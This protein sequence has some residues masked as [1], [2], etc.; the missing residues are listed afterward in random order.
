[1]CKQKIMAVGVVTVTIVC[2]ILDGCVS[3]EKISL[4]KIDT[5][6]VNTEKE[7]DALQ[8][9]QDM[10]E[11][12]PKTYEVCNKSFTSVCEETP[13]RKNVFAVGGKQIW[14][15]GSRSATGDVGNLK[16]KTYFVGTLEAPIMQKDSW[17]IKEAGID[18]PEDMRVYRMT[19]DN[20]GNAHLLWR[21]RKETKLEDSTFPME[22]FTDDKFKLMVVTPEGIVENESDVTGFMV[23]NKSMAFCF[24]VDNYGNY[25]MDQGEKIVK[26]TVEG[27]ILQEISCGGE[28]V[29]IAQGKSGAM[30]CVLDD[31]DR[32]EC[33]Y[34]LEEDGRLMLL[35]EVPDG[36]A[37]F[38]DMGAGTDTELILFR[39]DG[40][41]HAVDVAGDAATF[42]LRVPESDMPVSGQDIGGCGIL[43]DGRVCL[44][45]YK[46]E[47]SLLHYI[48][49]GR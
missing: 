9:F 14:M 43:G 41:I 37:L 7:S 8:K 47:G 12:D 40:G 4:S 49:V 17:R 10:S 1:M 26:F 33:L 36:V 27:E 22:I 15:C 5:V 42:T 16:D 46:E 44:F 21:S 30:Y 31:Q 6:E 20:L 18:I 48:A 32:A 13:L 3:K 29:S 2:V 24:T 28:V 23:E 45:Q 35:G 11:A 19:V 34:R 25:Y 39:M 38:P